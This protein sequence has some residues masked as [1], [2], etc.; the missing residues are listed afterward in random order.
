MTEQKPE[1]PK[2]EKEKKLPVN[3]MADEYMKQ[4]LT[5]LDKN[6]QGGKKDATNANS[7]GSNG[8]TP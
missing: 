7:D 3:F 2:T 8:S 6:K 4:Q 5:T 1:E